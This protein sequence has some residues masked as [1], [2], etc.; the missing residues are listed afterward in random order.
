VRRVTERCAPQ[1]GR[2]VDARLR[3]REP[4]RHVRRLFN[5]QRGQR[6]CAA[7][8]AEGGDD[9]AVS[10]RGKLVRRRGDLRLPCGG[11]ATGHQRRA[12]VHRQPPS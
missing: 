1:P 10:D 6:D 3:P 8:A 7:R 5:A 12:H 9:P 2:T 4:R 11:H